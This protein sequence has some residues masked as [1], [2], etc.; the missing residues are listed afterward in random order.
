MLSP[1]YSCSPRLFLF[2]SIVRLA[3]PPKPGIGFPQSLC[4]GS[5]FFLLRILF[6]LRLC[7]DHILKSISS[8]TNMGLPSFISCLCYSIAIMTFH[9]AHLIIHLCIYLSPSNCKLN[10]DRN[11]ISFLHYCIHNIPNSAWYIIGNE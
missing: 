1:L 9:C 3:F 5:F 6:F 11:C 8:P 7:F 4:S 10:E 2:Q